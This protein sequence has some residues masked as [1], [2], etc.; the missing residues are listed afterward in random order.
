MKKT[1]K[2]VKRRRKKTEEESL[3]E[4]R[5]GIVG[6]GGGGGSI[7]SGISPGLKKIFFTAVNTDK[8]ALEEVTK[9]KK[10]KGVVFGKRLTGGL[11]TG[12][13]PKL[14][15]QA[16]EED[17]EEVKK[18][19]TNLDIVIFTASLGGGTGCGALP[20]FAAAAREMG[21]LVY[22]VFTLPFSFEGEKKTR[23]AK[24]AVREAS[25]HLHAVTI[26]PNEKIFE[27]V[28][29]NT[30]LKEALM[31][32]NKSLAISL[33]G[34]VETIYETGLINIDFAD[35]RTVLENRRGSRKLAYLSTVDGNFEEGA[36]E[37]VR[38]AVSNPLYPYAIKKARGILVNITGGKD[39]GLTD[40]AA[41]SESIGQYTEDDAKIIIG[42]MQ[43]NKYKDKVRITLLATGCETEFLRKELE[44]ESSGDVPDVKTKEVKKGKDFQRKEKRE[45]DKKKKKN[46]TDQVTIMPA[47][48]EVNYSV[49][50]E[51][52][53]PESEEEKDILEQEKKWEKPAFLKR[54]N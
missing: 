10:I 15:K 48:R 53:H 23:A 34:L 8:H 46:K 38:K 18:I 13:N 1:K 4:I 30:P 35:V 25:P 45:S 41:I 26:M 51:R 44:K 2:S 14:G 31:V 20:V 16:A 6:I 39:I 29:K 12:M 50:E 19:F 37:I 49:E 43:K 47:K 24:E 9:K 11:G 42:I 36:E 5:V 54:I 52:K 22:G 28:D 33:E 7:I 21:C 32:I 3:R 27:V 40:I 17:I